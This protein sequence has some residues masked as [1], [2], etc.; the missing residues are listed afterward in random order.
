MKRDG[1]QKLTLRGK[2]TYDKRVSL[3]EQDTKRDLDRIK[4]S[5]VIKRVKQLTL[6]WFDDN[7]SQ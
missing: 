5:I 3:K 4:N 2:K 6:F 7:F 1:H